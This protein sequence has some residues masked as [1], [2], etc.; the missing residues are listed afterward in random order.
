V[1]LDVLMRDVS[2]IEGITAQVAAAEARGAGAVWTSESGVD[3][4]VP[5]AVAA[6]VPGRVGLGTSIAVAYGRSPYSTAQAAWHLQRLSLGRL[7]LG[8]ATQ[9]R[10]HIERRYGMPWPGGVGAMRE[11]VACC[12][13]I[14]RSWQTGEPPAFEGEHYRYTLTNPEFEPG[15]VPDAYADV[16]IWLAAVGRLSARLA[17]EI[18]EG[19]LVH[20]FHTE[21]HL[22]DVLMPE[23]AA[24]RLLAGRS[25]GARVGGVVFGGIAHDDTQARTMR[26]GFRRHVAFY[27]STKAYR[28]VMDSAGAG[29]LYEPLRALSRAGAWTEMADLVSDEL[30]DQFVVIDEPRALGRRLAAR[31]GGVMTSL[32]LYDGGDEFARGKDWVELQ[33][34]LETAP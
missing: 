9:V 31:Y 30:L 22:R 8:L 7:R 18:A 26:D 27:G 1:E 23:V 6:A 5:L 17:G 20:A 10:P 25:D 16:P 19:L 12:R 28:D 21:R 32:S 13:A 24:G 14:W 2:S 4:Y 33:A 11:Y 34:G 3:P 29:E 15:P